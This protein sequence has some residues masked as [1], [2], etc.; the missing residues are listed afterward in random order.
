MSFRAHSLHG[1]QAGHGFSSMSVGSPLSRKISKAGSQGGGF[2]MSTGGQ[3]TAIYNSRWGG[4]TGSL[5]GDLGGQF[6]SSSGRFLHYSSDLGASAVGFSIAGSGYGGGV[7][8]ASYGGGAGHKSLPITA[9]TVDQSLLAPLNLQIDPRIGQIKHEEK[10]QI[11]TLNNTFANFIDKVRILEQKNAVLRTKWELLQQQDGGAAGRGG[12]NDL[13]PI[14]KAHIQNL[15]K[16]L[17]FQNNERQRLENE[18]NAMQQT[19]DNFR[20]RYEDEINLHFDAENEFVVLK[21]EVDAAYIDKI[22]LEANAEKLTDEMEFLR[23]LHALEKQAMHSNIEDIKAIVQ[24]NNNREFDLQ[25]ILDI[26]KAQYDEMGKR[27]RG[28]SEQYYQKKY[29]ELEQSAGKSGD[30]IKNTK[31]EI[32]ELQRMIRKLRNEIEKVNQQC[33]TLESQIAH[34]EEHGEQ[35]LQ[36]ARAKLAELQTALQKAKEDMAFKLQ[37]Y[38]EL[39]NIKMQLDMEIAT[40]NKLLCGEEG[41]LTGEIGTDATVYVQ[42]SSSA[43]GMV[44]RGSGGGLS[45]GGGGGQ[46][47]AGRVTGFG[48][49]S[50]GGSGTRDIASSSS[51]RSGLSGGPVSKPKAA[52]IMTIETGHS[53]IR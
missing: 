27:T 18:N 31:H 19:I 6:S 47:A 15:Q 29:R 14:Y 37:Q 45:L 51:I 38:Q 1:G 2:R 3:T 48:S 20:N 24:I 8:T 50:L 34:A 35:A 46:S 53:I 39:M 25:G 44:T 30:D 41:R 10:E 16:Q 17:D 22:N 13:T 4:G 52:I 32:A 9:V 11:K 33:A 12:R 49:T 28:D 42:S 26:Y 23:N 40:Y 5:Y 36:D 7:S 21:K 43:A